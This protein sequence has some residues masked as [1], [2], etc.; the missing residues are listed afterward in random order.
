MNG[1]PFA[2]L[3]IDERRT[4]TKPRRRGLTMMIDP[5]LPPALA[6]DIVACAGAYIDFAKFKTGTARLYSEAVLREKIEC[7]RTNDIKPFIGGQ[8]HEY[9]VATT[10]GAAL[11]QFYAE[12]L[13]LGFTAIEVSD[14]VVPLT[15]E[16]RRGFIRRARDA[17]LE[18]FGE[19]GGKDRRS[20]PQELLD[21][22]GLCLEA[23]ASIVLVEAAELVFEGKVDRGLLDAVLTG[24]RPE[25]VMVELPGPWIPEVRH[26]DIEALKKMLVEEFGPDVNVANVLPDTILDFEATRSGLGVAGPLG[27]ASSPAQA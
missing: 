16:N 21:Q 25:D 12:A 17:G 11:S 22:A 5:G 20:S 13:R 18:V 10:Q 26:C 9:V 24:L 7:Y 14:N 19:V 6:R 27:Y 3:P 4:R 1:A 2:F 8:F 23:G 15:P